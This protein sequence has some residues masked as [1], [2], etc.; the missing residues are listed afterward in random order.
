MN[1]IPRPA[2]W[3]TVCLLV[4]SPLAI[5]QQESQSTQETQTV[6]GH[7]Q[8]QAAQAW[9]LSQKE[10]ERYQSIMKGPRGTWSP[11]LDPLTALGLEARS[12]AERQKYAEQLVKTERARVES[13]LAFQRAYDAAWKRLY[14][15]DMPV[16]AFS[17]KQ[18]ADKTRSVF[19][20]SPS[21]SSQRL[22]V[23]VATQGCPRCVAVVKRLINTGSAMNIWVVDAKGNDDRIR[24]WATSIGIPPGEVRS[25]HVTL[26]HGDALQV[27]PS[28]LPRVA[29]RG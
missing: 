1:P 14:P 4:A 6:I 29:P 25:G 19:G 13:E 12:D 9:G 23:V 22:D 26:N 21:T 28:E 11:N 3:L 8:Q 5:A 16:N 24:R 15:G 7:S 20:D 27:D 17:S 10:Y 18:E 2:F